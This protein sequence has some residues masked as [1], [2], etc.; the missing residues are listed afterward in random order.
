MSAPVPGPVIKIRLL[1]DASDAAWGFAVDYIE[2]VDDSALAYST[3]PY[4]NGV[5]EVQWVF[6]GQGN[7]SATRVIFSHLGLEENVDY[8][9]LSDEGGTPYQWITGAYP[10]GSPP[11]SHMRKTGSSFS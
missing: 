7:A 3:H 8:V 11:D 2:G 1:S 4:E 5:N 10:S 6:N 9:I